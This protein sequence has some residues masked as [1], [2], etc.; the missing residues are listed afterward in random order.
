MDLFALATELEQIDTQRRQK[1]FEATTMNAISFL[2]A[3]IGVVKARFKD[4]AKKKWKWGLEILEDDSGN[5]DVRIENELRIL[6]PKEHW[7]SFQ[8]MFMGKLDE[9]SYLNLTSMLDEAMEDDLKNLRLDLKPA[10]VEMY[11]GQRFSSLDKVAKIWV[12]EFGARSYITRKD[13]VVVAQES[14]ERNI[15]KLCGN[16]LRAYKDDKGGLEML[17]NDIKSIRP[18]GA[19]EVFKKYDYLYGTRIQSQ[20]EDVKLIFEVTMDMTFMVS[21]SIVVDDEDVLDELEDRISSVKRVGNILY[22]EGEQFKPSLFR[23]IKEV[24]DDVQEA[25]ESNERN[26]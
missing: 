25:E 19:Y 6:V 14:K 5:K 18:L 4:M 15:Q 12:S 11:H 24:I 13:K 23:T 8:E 7:I 26:T 2:P 16:L 20:Y 22:P 17:T 21:E 1:L 3:Q 9:D 10:L